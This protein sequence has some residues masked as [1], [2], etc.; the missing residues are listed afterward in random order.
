[1]YNGQPTICAVTEFC[2]FYENN[3]H[4]L[5]LYFYKFIS[6]WP[7]V[8]GAMGVGQK[9]IKLVWWCH[10]LLTENFSHC[11]YAA[12]DAHGAMGCDQKIFTLVWRCSSC[13][14]PYPTAACPEFHVGCRLG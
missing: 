4:Y 2:R 11:P 9:S 5:Q 6:L 7:F 10:Q 8:H 3:E 1:M 14:V 12:A 13:P